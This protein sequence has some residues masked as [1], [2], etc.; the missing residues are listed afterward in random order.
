MA[1]GSWQEEAGPGGNSAAL[2]ALASSGALRDPGQ[3]LT[4][5]GERSRVH[6]TKG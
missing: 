4:H 3:H 1:G 5:R 6:N 2:G